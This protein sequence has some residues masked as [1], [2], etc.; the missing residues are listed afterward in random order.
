MRKE[1]NHKLFFPQGPNE[2]WEYLTNPELMELW[3]MKNDFQ[4][5]VGHA[6]QF[7][8]NPAPSIDFDGVVYCTVLEA[9]PFEKL[10]YSWKCGPGVGKITIDSVVTWTLIPRDGGTELQ[11]DHS[12][13]KVME[14]LMIFTAMDQG[15]QKNINKIY[16]LINKQ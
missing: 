5:V 6:F 8:S 12:A 1:I 16:E 10:S 4:P 9:K 2:V 11:L 13:F 7:R 14:N 15:W 3:L